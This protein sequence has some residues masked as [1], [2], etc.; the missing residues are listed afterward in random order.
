MTDESLACPDIWRSRDLDTSRCQDPWIQR[1]YHSSSPGISITRTRSTAL[2]C[3]GPRGLKEG[4]RSNSEC[5]EREG[6][7]SNTER[8]RVS[9]RV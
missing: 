7:E 2:V 3:T 4:I 9:R 5:E 6:R 8:H 1:S